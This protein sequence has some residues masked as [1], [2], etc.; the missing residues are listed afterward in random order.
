M[1]T[2]LPTQPVISSALSVTGT[3]G[4]AFSYQIAASNNP[5]S[6]GATGLPTWLS[7]NTSTGLLSGTAP[8][9]ASTTSTNVTIAASNAGGTGT[10][11]LSITILPT[12]PVINSPSSV[13]GTGGSALSYQITASKN[14]TSFGATG[15]PTWLSI[16]TSTGRL[17]GTA[18]V[19]ASTTSTNVNIAASNAGGTGTA[20]LS[21][22]ILPTQPV[23]TSA[24]SVTGTA[25]YAFSFQI[26]ATNNPTNFGATGVPSWLNINQSTGLLSGTPPVSGSTT[27]IS[28]T[29]AASNAGGTGTSSLT[30][31][32]LQAPPVITS[33]SSATGIVGTPF[34][35]QIVATGGPIS[36]SAG[37]LS[38]GLAC[39]T[40][41]GLISG[42]PTGSGTFNATLS[43]SNSTG[44][45]TAGLL[46]VVTCPYIYTI[47]SSNTITITGYT[48]T[49]GALTIPSVINGLPVTAIGDNAFRNCT[50]L[51]SVTIPASIASIGVAPFIGC[52]NL[53]SI[54]VIA[55]NA[56]YSSLNGVLFNNTQT[57]LIE[58]PAGLGGSYTIPNGV[59]TIGYAFD[60]CTQLTSVTIPNSVVT[61]GS[62][63]FANCTGL[64]N[65]AIPNSVTT[66][67]SGAFNGCPGL[68]TVTIPTGVTTIGSSTF[69][70]DPGLT[71]VTIPNGVATIGSYA[72][73]AC[74]NLTSVTIPG[75]VTSIGDDAFNSCTNLISAIFEGNAPTM[76]ASVFDSTASGFT[77]YF[78]TGAAGFTMPTWQGYHSVAF[79]ITSV[80]TV[81]G[82]DGAPFGYQIAANNNPASYGATPLPSGLNINA[83]SGMISGTPTE[84]GTFDTTITAA[85]VTGTCTATLVITVVLA[86]PS[87][88]GPLNVTGTAGSPFGYQ[89]IAS[90]N[91]A[92]YTATGLPAGLSVS[93]AT[94]LIS[95]T[96]ISTG[97]TNVNISASNAAGT[98]TGT[99]IITAVTPA[100]WDLVKNWSDAWN[101]NGVW[102]FNTGTIPLP[103]EAGWARADSRHRSR[104]G[105][106]DPFCV[107]QGHIGHQRASWSG[108]QIGSGTG[109]RRDHANRWH[110]Q[111]YMDQSDLGNGGY[112]RV[113]VAGKN[114]R[115]LGKLGCAGQ[116]SAGD[117]REHFRG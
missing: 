110:R 38:A 69:N 51:T 60:G 108:R 73:F 62:Y 37:P 72:F 34:S 99:L 59:I 56:N 105:R 109:R 67:G 18:P 14:P 89:I 65:V 13:T 85:S 21:I 8:V 19:S 12:R 23:I 107:V 49:G 97:T 86:P 116:W 26:T 47:S 68:T 25:G 87:I 71:T 93:N 92:S 2:I 1:I 3:G 28:G 55:P 81:T 32:V 42:T 6:F 15:L 16:N 40:L 75:S 9:S 100:P 78:Y 22:T 106:K 66:I 74:P 103:A 104:S 83:S 114:D 91:P 88:N 5:T 33:G 52:S 117:R 80:L 53:T 111:F 44:S 17:S 24:S 63:A 113:L 10:A 112:I 76:G 64:G 95:G 27:S 41:T 11:N 57:T 102:S 7:I 43:A 46:L 58:F 36:Y 48:G 70:G 31:T 98:G 115:A 84:T 50:T 30:I 101:P 54:N 79:G 35:Y 4:N 82:T 77:V 20:N 90:N 45:G 96:L 61:I 29:L 94:G 39:N